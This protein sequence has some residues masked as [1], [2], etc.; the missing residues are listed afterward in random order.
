MASAVITTCAFDPV[1]VF[2]FCLV[3][4]VNLGNENEVSYHLQSCFFFI[5][6]DKNVPS[7]ILS[8]LSKYIGIYKKVR[9]TL[10][11]WD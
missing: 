11:K 7:V 1:I 5:I 10:I 6:Y 4:S 9:N 3:F 2:H 8:T